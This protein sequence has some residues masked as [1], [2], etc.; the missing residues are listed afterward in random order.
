MHPTNQISRQAR[1]AK[2]AE[3]HI[4]RRQTKRGGPTVPEDVIAQCGNRVRLVARHDPDAQE[5]CRAIQI[6]NTALLY[7]IEGKKTS[8]RVR[9]LAVSRIEKCKKKNT[10]WPEPKIE[11]CQ[12]NEKNAKKCGVE[13]AGMCPI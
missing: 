11:Q 12:K 6:K 7:K 13:T 5:Q 3:A 9:A 8:K 1:A 10:R 2:P 4:D